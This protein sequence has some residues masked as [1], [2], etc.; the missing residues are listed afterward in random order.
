[1]DALRE[2]FEVRVIVDA[3]RPVN[4][5]SDDG[6]RALKEIQESGAVLETTLPR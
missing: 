5:H 3:T 4:V 1:M 6:P 2:G